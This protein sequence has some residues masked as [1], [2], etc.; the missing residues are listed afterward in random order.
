MADFTFH[1][2]GTIKI[3]SGGMELFHQ[4]FGKTY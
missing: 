3:E 1:M 2:F 4:Y